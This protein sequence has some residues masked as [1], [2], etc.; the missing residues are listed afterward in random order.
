M[1]PV[2]VR[3]GLLWE[4]AELHWLERFL[5]AASLER[6]ESLTV[7][8]LPVGDLYG[9][10]W[11][12]SGED[13]PGYDTALDSNYLPGRNLLLL[14]KVAVLCALRGIEHVAMA[15]LADNPFSDGT[16]E[17][18]AAFAS[19]AALAL[20]VSL[21]IETPFRRLEKAEVV[22]RGEGLPLALTFSCIRPQGFSHCG[23]CTKCAERQ[24]GFAAAGVSDPTVYCGAPRS[25]PSLRLSVE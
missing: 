11:S 2:Y 12:L 8:D 21:R 10:H 19:T 14:S 20:S 25:S 9:S 3:A 22:R 6:C 4:S 7:L 18:F 1:L 15:P 17:F 16:R 23:R 13:V 24:R 5:V